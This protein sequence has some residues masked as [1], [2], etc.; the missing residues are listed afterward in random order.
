[1]VLQEK[2]HYMK[3]SIGIVPTRDCTHLLKIGFV[4]AGGGFYSYYIHQGNKL[5]KENK[6]KVSL[7]R[8]GAIPRLPI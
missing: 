8:V 6:I 1:M 3:G 2:V 4:V 7:A 5:V